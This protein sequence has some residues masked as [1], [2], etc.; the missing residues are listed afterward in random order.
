M[1][2]QV[3]HHLK[4]AALLEINLAERE[5]LLALLEMFGRSVG[6]SIVQG[7]PLRRWFDVKYEAVLKQKMDYLWQTDPE[8]A[9][10]LQVAMQAMTDA[11]TPNEPGPSNDPP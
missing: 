2:H 6:V 3:P 10:A 1:K 11:T 5:A 8:W 9:A 4:A 7:V